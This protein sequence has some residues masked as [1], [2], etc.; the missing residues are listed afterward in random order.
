MARKTQTQRDVSPFVFVVIALLR[1]KEAWCNLELPEQLTPDTEVDT[2]TCGQVVAATYQMS[3]FTL[4]EKPKVAVERLANIVPESHR[5]K[6]IPPARRY[7][8]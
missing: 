6:Y 5:D 3:G 1:E 7:R 4:P 2:A 8:S